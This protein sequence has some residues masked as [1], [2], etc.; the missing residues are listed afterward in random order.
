[1]SFQAE[2]GLKKKTKF[3]ILKDSFIYHKNERSPF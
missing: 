3:V 2:G 1:M